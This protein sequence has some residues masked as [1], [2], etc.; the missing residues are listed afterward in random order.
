MADEDPAVGAPILR[1]ATPYD[2]PFLWE[3]LRE[4]AS[5]ARLESEEPYA[6]EDLLA[7][8]QMADYVAGWGRAGDAG[9]VAEVDGQPAGAC[10]FR[11]FTAEHPGYGFLGE[12]IPGLGFAVRPDRRRRGIGTRLLEGA[13]E[14]AREQ[15][16]PALSLSVEELNEPA[17]RLYVRAGFVVVGREGEAFTMRLDLPAARS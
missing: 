8:S 1:E 14:L 17:Q 9:V 13:I 16:H 4:A 7:I 12:D 2:E 5:W 3:M 6:L 15:G 11:R 10:W